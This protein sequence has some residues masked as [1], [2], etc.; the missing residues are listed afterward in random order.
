[1]NIFITYLTEKQNGAIRFSQITVLITDRTSV[2]SE[3]FCQLNF[4]KNLSQGLLDTMATSGT[5]QSENYLCALFE[6]GCRARGSD[7]TF[8]SSTVVAG[9]KR[10]IMPHYDS[11]YLEVPDGSLVVLSGTPRYSGYCARIGR[12]WPAG[13]NAKFSV[14]ESVANMLRHL[15]NVGPEANGKFFGEEGEAIPW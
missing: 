1:M 12:T 8:G 9:D 10:A 2:L 11:N 7:N 15:E 5:N 3:N 4:S 13:E 6:F 14:E